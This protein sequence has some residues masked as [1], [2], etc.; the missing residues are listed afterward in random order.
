MREALQMRKRAEFDALSAVARAVPSLREAVAITS[1]VSEGCV[2][3]SHL[4]NLG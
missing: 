4:R 1:D 2:S 3:L